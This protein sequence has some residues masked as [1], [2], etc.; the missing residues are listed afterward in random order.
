MNARAH[1]VSQRVAK[2]IH[3]N[4]LVHIYWNIVI[5]LIESMLW[6]Q[7]GYEISIAY[8]VCDSFAT[9]LSCLDL[10][11]FLSFILHYRHSRSASRLIMLC[12]CGGKTFS[13]VDYFI[14]FT[15]LCWSLPLSHVPFSRSITLTKMACVCVCWSTADDG[16]CLLACWLR[17]CS[18][19]CFLI[20]ILNYHFSRA[21]ISSFNCRAIYFL[22]P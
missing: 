4:R 12:Q 19:V 18:N 6:V 7:T 16:I 13:V 2:L 3:T 9:S 15:H 1:L 8:F 11:L 21:A 14:R 22:Q 20:E 10:S 5:L 17:L